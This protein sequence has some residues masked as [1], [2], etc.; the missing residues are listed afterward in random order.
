MKLKSIVLT[1]AGSVAMC[2]A[3]VFSMNWLIG[4]V[5]SLVCERKPMFT[6][7]TYLNT[8]QCKPRVAFPAPMYRPAPFTAEA[9]VEAVNRYDVANGVADCQVIFRHSQGYEVA[10]GCFWLLNESVRPGNS[11]SIHV[12]NLQGRRQVTSMTLWGLR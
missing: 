11:F 2:A 8:L 4:D 5:S 7:K 12:D 3:F 1:I 6:G 9:V 10:H